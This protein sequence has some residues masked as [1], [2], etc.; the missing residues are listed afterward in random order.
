MFL[1]KSKIKA[2]GTA[3]RQVEAFIVYFH[4][5]TENEFSIILM[6]FSFS[7]FDIDFTIDFTWIIY[8]HHKTENIN[9][10]R[11]SF[12]GSLDF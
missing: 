7:L 1:I 5:F 3:D 4:S 12:E 6:N 8:F 10:N 11:K 9:K 2:N